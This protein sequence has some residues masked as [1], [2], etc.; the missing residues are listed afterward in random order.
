LHAIDSA[1]ASGALTALAVTASSYSTGLHWTFCHTASDADRRPWQSPGRRGAFQPLTF[2]HLLA[3]SAIPLLFPAIALNLDLRREYF[4]DGSMRQSSPLSPAL[5]LGAHRILVIGA[6][7]PQ[8]AAWAG[9]D[10][11]EPTV[12]TI[13]GHAL[14]S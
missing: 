7:Q 8:R 4:G 10:Q 13:A 2:D 14:A 11:P 9:S 5:R 1:L 3:S 12:G 6:G